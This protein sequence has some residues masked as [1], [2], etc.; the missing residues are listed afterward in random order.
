[1]HLG[2]RILRHHERSHERL[3]IGPGD[4]AGDG[5]SRCRGGQQAQGERKERLVR[6]MHVASRVVSLGVAAVCPGKT[7]EQPR[8]WNPGKTIAKAAHAANAPNCFPNGY[9]PG[10]SPALAPSPTLD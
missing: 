10:A 6:E 2:L 9:R 5:C 8:R 1:R 3:A 7:L 4:G